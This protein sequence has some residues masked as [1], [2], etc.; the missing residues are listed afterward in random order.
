[1]TLVALVILPVAARG[2]RR[3]VL[4]LAVLGCFA[5]FL[6]F[7]FRYGTCRTLYAPPIGIK[8]T[9]HF[10]LVGWVMLW[11]QRGMFLK[12]RYRALRRAGCVVLIARIPA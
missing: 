7:V 10:L 4:P 9:V 12:V 6:A 8:L 2:S 1:M 5:S 11:W 3:L